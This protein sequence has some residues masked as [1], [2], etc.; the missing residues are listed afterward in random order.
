[1]SEPGP[2]AE[3]P[4]SP[5]DPTIAGVIERPG[6]RLLRPS[7][8]VRDIGGSYVVNGIIGLI[9]SASGPVA[10][11]LAAGAA[12][13]LGTAEL[14][15]WIFG[16]FVLNGILT[17]SASWV[18]RMPLAFA[19]TI[20]G[21]VLV[22]ASLKNGLTW[23]EVLG[24]FLI[25]GVLILVASRPL[26]CGGDRKHEQNRADRDDHNKTRSHQARWHQQ[27]GTQP[28]HVQHFDKTATGVRCEITRLRVRPL[29]AAR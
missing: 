13:N 1:M 9:F 12:G 14:T 18:Y 4:E 27:W 17:M 22:G 10:V 20:P 7:A 25:T 5:S 21:T 28:R 6:R 24:A 15:S 29:L 19:W 8:V 23:P 11:I 2:E 26:V 16:V 3:S